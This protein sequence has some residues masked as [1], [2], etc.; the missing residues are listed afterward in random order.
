MMKNCHVFAK[1]NTDKSKM[2]RLRQFGFRIFMKVNYIHVIRAF[3]FSFISFIC[4]QP[5]VA[6]QAVTFKTGT[7]PV[8]TT[9]ASSRSSTQAEYH[10]F[11]ADHVL[12]PGEREALRLQGI[13]ILYAL[14][15]HIYWVR[16]KGL[17]N[18]NYLKYFFDLSPEYKNTITFSERSDFNKLRLTIAPGMA[19]SEIESWA[20][21]NTISLLD[22][23]AMNFGF[24]DVEVR[25]S[26]ME[27]VINTPWI[28]YIQSIPHD[29]QVNYRLLNAERGWGLKSPLTRNLD[30]SGIT[31]GIGDGGRLGTHE[32]LASSVLDL[33]SFALSNHATQVSGIVT[34]AGLLDPAFGFGYAPNA[35]VILRNFSDILWS[36]PQYISDF[37]MS[38]TNNSYG[39][40]LTDCRYLG[41]YDGTSAALDEMIVVYPSLLHVFS[42]GNSG[43]QTCT[44]FPAGYANVL[45]GYQPAKNVLTVGA[46]TITDAIAGFSSRGP[47]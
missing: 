9:T 3:I 36:S 25:G 28:A 40:A 10:F 42:S 2:P 24:I 46:I 34:G 6:Q 32:D 16:I 5:S 4:C 21:E 35:H 20:A 13:E 45:G 22:L 7:F 37:G 41:D 12:T 27:K 23:R 18:D 44:P 15:D 11:A 38:L 14:Q 30:G 1:T 33:S 19:L 47:V 8:L 17:T 26:G 31:V 29:E 43:G 39:S